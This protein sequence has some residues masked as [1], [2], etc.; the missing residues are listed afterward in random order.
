MNQT[1]R[2]RDKYNWSADAWVCSKT[3]REASLDFRRVKSPASMALLFSIV[4]AT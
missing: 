4:P 2:G 3:K 1:C